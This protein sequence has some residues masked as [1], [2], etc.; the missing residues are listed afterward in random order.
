MKVNVMMVSSIESAAEY[1]WREAK[2]PPQLEVNL[3][4]LLLL[5]VQ[6]LTLQAEALDEP[7]GLRGVKSGHFR[8]IVEF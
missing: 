6:R 8:G 4:N 7:S 2:P 1:V 3:S 5:A